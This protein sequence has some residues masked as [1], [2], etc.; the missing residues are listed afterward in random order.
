MT[1]LEP[2][3]T[4][5]SDLDPIRFEILQHRLQCMTEEAATALQRVS[6]S[7]VATQIGDMN[8]GLFDAAGQNVVIGQFSV[9]KATGLSQ[10]IEHILA[11]F[12]EN[13]G[14]AP[15]DAFLGNDP[16][17][18]IM[19]QNDVCLL[20]PIFQ[21]G[22]LIAWAG[23]DIHQVDV[24]GPT[25]GQVQ[26]GARDI[27]GEAPLIPP[28]KVI[29]A[30]QWRKDVERWYLRNCRLP[31]VVALDLRAK[32]AAC[33]SLE[34]HLQTLHQQLGP[35]AF[36]QFFEK[37]I[38]TTESM[39]R[40]KLALIPDG[41]WAHRNYLEFDGDIYPLVV[42]AEKRGRELTLDF[43]G[44]A[45]QAAATINMT[46]KAVRA[47]LAGNLCDTLM[48]DIPWHIGGLNRVVKVKTEPGTIV[49][50]IFPAGVSKS[51]TSIGLLMSSTVKMA[52]SKMLRSSGELAA[53]AC[54]G[55]PG[56]KAQEELH[57]TN[58]HG[59]PFA[60]DILDGMAGG[61]GA[62]MN[63]DG[64]D[65]GG[66]NAVSKISISN[67]EHYEQEYPILYLYRRELADAGGAGRFR[68]GN[69][70]DRAYVVH[71]AERIPDVVMH[72]IGSKVPITSGLEGGCPSAT[73]QFQ[74]K[75]GTRINE[76]LA[77][78]H[79]PAHF[80]EIEG[81]VEYHPAI[82]RTSFE[83]G[84]VYRAISVCGGGFGDPLDRELTAIALDVRLGS[85]TPVNARAQYFA[86]ISRDGSVDESASAQL[87]QAERQRRQKEAKPPVK[88][89]PSATL[90]ERRFN[91]VAEI[92]WGIAEDGKAYLFAE[93]DPPMVLCPKHENVKDYLPFEVFPANQLGPHIDTPG[94]GSAEFHLWC[95]YHPVTWRR[96]FCE[97][98][99]IDEIPLDEVSLLS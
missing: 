80:A 32:L 91:L 69:G 12:A 6:A 59:R 83:S 81:E 78:G 31:Q 56:G 86:A 16:Y 13:P 26:L 70:I 55:W 25:P 84:D 79:L 24:G 9:A 21:D 50:P 58:Q 46:A 99:R 76:T 5:S 23:A 67:V 90:V 34:R 22:D 27:F 42:A 82:S 29:D 44:T 15:G 7:P 63:K 17:L 38:S 94:L 2:P 18:G 64:M 4:S 11:E 47:W 14:I 98:K 48:R 49:D 41:R 43:T 88:T 3:P 61:G 54:A 89:S 62:L 71:G 10:V 97:V 65:S 40:A 68:G 75:R 8:V 93:H 20:L 19:H 36:V 51:T 28:M 66:L 73:N 35:S 96:L 95:A 45:K 37:L 57:G 30:G 87:R 53:S 1:T 92:F 77:Q 74:I 60:A 72:A 85:I 39:L 33:R 52:L